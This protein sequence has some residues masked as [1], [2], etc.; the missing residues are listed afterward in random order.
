LMLLVMTFMCC[1]LKIK[2][3][4]LNRDATIVRFDDDNDGQRELYFED[5]YGD[6]Y[7]YDKGKI[8]SPDREFEF[9]IEQLDGGFS[10]TRLL[11]IDEQD[12]FYVSVS[13]ANIRNI[14]KYD[15]RGQLVGIAK[16]PSDRDKIVHFPKK[17]RDVIFKGENEIYAMANYEDKTVIY[18]VV[19]GQKLPELSEWEESSEEETKE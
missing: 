1:L 13:E 17:D 5:D 6:K 8:I 7:K 14:R 2:N 18:E 11:Y 3:Y 4:L 15:S 16:L 12:N 9:D 10:L 19:L